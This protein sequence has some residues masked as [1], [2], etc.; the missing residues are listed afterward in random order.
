MRKAI[1]NALYFENEAIKSPNLIVRGGVKLYLQNAFVS[2]TSAK[3]TNP[4]CD[5]VLVVND[6]LPDFWEEIFAHSGIQIIEVPFDNYRFPAGFKWEYAFY[7]LKVLEYMVNN[8]C[9]DYFLGVDT[10][11]YFS[12]ELK[13]LWEEC[14]FDYP[15]LYSLD[16]HIQSPTRSKVIKD[17]ENLYSAYLP[18]VQIGGEFVAGTKT[19]LSKLSDNI[20]SIYSKIRENN[21][22]IS[23]DSGDEAILSMAAFGMKTLPAV[24]YVRRYWGRRAFYDVDSAWNR[25][26]IW[27]LPAEKNYGLL[28][29]Y[30]KIRKTGKLPKKKVAAKMFNLAIQRKYNLSMLRYYVH[31]VLKK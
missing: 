24:S 22:N 26:P 10:D 28:V 17:Y 3:L 27:H 2:L 23:Q 31:C 4:D 18:I 12:D 15:L 16:A 13:M 14:K 19:A 8:T 20:E 29:M 11:T 1:Y 25:I 21:F 5:A 9:Y 30:K 7:K 6:K